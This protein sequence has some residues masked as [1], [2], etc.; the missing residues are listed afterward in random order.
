[1]SADYIKRGNLLDIFDSESG[2]WYCGTVA[3]VIGDQNMIMHFPHHE[4]EQ[5]I[6]SKGMLM[7]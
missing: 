7:L 5:L 2:L 1:L 3:K 6:W 4:S